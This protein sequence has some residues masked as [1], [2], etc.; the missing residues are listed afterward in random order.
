MSSLNELFV[1]TKNLLDQLEKPFPKE[2]REEYI[3]QMEQMIDKR[4][5]LIQSYQGGPAGTEQEKKMVNVIIDWNKQIDER[6]S[7][8]LSM[9]RVDLNNLKKRKTTGVKYENP[10]QYG[11][12][13]GS[14][15]DKKK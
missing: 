6:M 1:A 12:I 13:D 15:I 10:Y 8:Y 7:S 11:P 4:E 9:V 5:Q 2:D 3:E 14:F